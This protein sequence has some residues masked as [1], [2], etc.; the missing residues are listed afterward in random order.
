MNEGFLG[1][2]APRYADVVLLLEIGMGSASH[3]CGAR[4]HEAVSAARMVPV[5]HCAPEPCRC[6]TDNDSFISRSCESEDTAQTWDGLL[7]T[8][9]SAWGARKRHGNR[10]IVHPARCRHERFATQLPNDRIQT[11]D[12][13]SARALVARAPVGT[14]N[15]RPLVCPG[16][17]SEM[18]RGLSS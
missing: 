2:A 4:A 7:R 17:V 6:Y 15:I 13:Q 16:L 10:R 1:T 5:R 11:M 3:R 9:D 14:C 12:A 18:N 8:G